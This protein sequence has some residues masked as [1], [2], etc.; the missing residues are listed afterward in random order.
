[1]R[2][3]I[4][5]KRKN[6]KNIK[7]IKNTKKYKKKYYKIFEKYKLLPNKIAIIGLIPFA[8]IALYYKS[9]T[10]LTILINGLIFHSRFFDFN[11]MLYI[12]TIINII[13]IISCII[14]SKFDFFIIFLTSIGTIVFL[15]TNLISNYFKKNKKI[16]TI[17]HTIFIQGFG[18]LGLLK[19]YIC[20]T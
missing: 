5:K 15:Y 18:A 10:A 16:S 17:F 4:N 13:L 7:N 19:F 3:F 12:D 6:I 14:K 1:M 11:I 2:K 9:L 20:Y 8:Y